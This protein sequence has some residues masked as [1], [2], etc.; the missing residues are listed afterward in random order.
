MAEFYDIVAWALDEDL[1][2]ITSE[3]IFRP[4]ERGRAQLV[5]KAD[6]VI[7]G[8]TLAEYTFMRVESSSK[9]TAHVKDGDAVKIGDV[10]ADIESTVI[11]L[12]SAE[13]TALNL[14]Q[15]GSGI[16]TTTRRY[17]EAVAGTRAK[18]YDTRKTMPGLRKLDKF[19]VRCGG[20]EN[21]RM[22]LNDMYLVK[23]NHI[24][25]AGSIDAA[26]NPIYETGHPDEGIMVEVRN[27][28]E[29]RQAM[30]WMPD[31][32][33]LDNM[34]PAQIRE[35]VE[36]TDGYEIEL[37]ASGGITLENVRQY[38]ETGV[39]RISIGALTHSVTALDISM[40]MVA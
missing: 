32:I 7:A 2:D 10:I 6:G 16:A 23:D 3:A 14:L 35:C 30:Q 38:A 21:H 37:E 4:D 18:I 34:T 40:R 20:G 28:T 33:L 5:M 1:P 8:L 13:R 36:I 22:S 31:Y 12:L 27:T 15:R 19:A 26:L 29:L 17:V 39:H 11:G 9:F 24:D 25:R